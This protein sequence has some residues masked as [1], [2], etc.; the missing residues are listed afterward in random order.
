MEN[1]KKFLQLSSLQRRALLQALWML[2]LCGCAVR[3]AG[4]QRCQSALIRLAGVITRE[5][6]GD[7]RDMLAD[8]RSVARVVEAASQQGCYR[9]RCLQKSLVLWWLLRRMGIAAEVW[10]GV[11]KA[12]ALVHAH[13]WVEFSGVVLNDKEDV[14]RDFAAFMSPISSSG[15]RLH[16]A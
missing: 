10:F 12:A 7:L 14:R 6:S 2:P 3:F 15:I 4:L 1:V 5:K 11:H 13:A 9:A 16:H 8:A